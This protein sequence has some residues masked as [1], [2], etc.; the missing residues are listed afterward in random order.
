MASLEVTFS[1]K[2]DTC[3]GALRATTSS[4]YRGNQLVYVE[5]CKYC[6]DAAKEDGREEARKEAEPDGD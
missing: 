3:K 4:D 1:V 5:P 2:C 6:L